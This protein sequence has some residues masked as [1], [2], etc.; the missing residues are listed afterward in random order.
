VIATM[1]T[2]YNRIWTQPM[3]VMVDVPSEQ[4]GLEQCV[5]E[6]EE[7]AGGHEAGKRIVENHGRSSQSRSQA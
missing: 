2:Q 5:D 6:V 3:T 1:I 4:L 7:Q